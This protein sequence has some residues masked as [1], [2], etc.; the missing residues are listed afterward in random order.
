MACFNYAKSKIIKNSQKNII[1]RK[2]ISRGRGGGLAV[3]TAWRSWLCYTVQDTYRSKSFRGRRVHAL[4]LYSHQLLRIKEKECKVCGIA[5]TFWTQL[6]ESHSWAQSY[7]SENPSTPR[8]PISKEQT[9]CD[10]TRQ[11][12]QKTRDPQMTA[13]GLSWST[14]QTEPRSLDKTLGSDSECEPRSKDVH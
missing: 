5:G 10:F 4:V 12:N 14:F 1:K 9:L 7:L 11:M 6:S 8:W 3:P 2:R 13:C